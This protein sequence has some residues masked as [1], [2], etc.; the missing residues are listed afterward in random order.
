VE[1]RAFRVRLYPTGS[2]R[3]LLEK[4]FG[5]NRFTWNYF[6]Q[7]RTEYYAESKA[8]GKAQGMNYFKTTK[9]LTQLKGEKEWL[10]EISSQSLQQTLR[11]LDNAFTAFFRKNSSYPVFR[12]KK[13]KQ[14]FV[15][16]QGAKCGED[17][18]FIPK[19]MEGIRFRD[20]HQIPEEINQVIVT[21]EVDRYY[22]SIIYESDEHPAKGNEQIGIDM[23]LKTFAT[24]SNGIQIENP[25]SMNKFERG[26]KRQQ[27]KLSGK[28]KG[29]KNRA[30]QVIRIR[31]L[32]Q[33]LTDAR[34][35]FLHKASTAIAKQS[36][37]IVME[38]LN[39]QGMMRNHHL[40]KS[41]GDVS[42]YSFKRMLEYKAEWRGIEFIE[43]GMF[44]ASSRV[45]S[46]C[47]WYKRDL[48]LSD[49]VFH[50]NACGLVID[51]DLN[52]AIN[53]RNMGLIKVGRGTPE[54]TPVE[55][56]TSAELFNR[57][58]LRDAGQ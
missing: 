28:E 4:H 25:H 18:L 39:I 21:K 58:G 11:K 10:Y 47:G 16:P 37:T 26:I 7:K 27:K 51:R 34:E 23:G 54:F 49:R 15:T 24:L 36:D 35:D 42:W 9:L 17:R 33:H 12:S 43:I 45:C 8:K 44:E 31:K 22:A 48:K 32:Y 29:S 40:A 41:I 2:Q 5:A 57:G 19:F 38:D 55:I 20:K 46:R 1:T 3:E 30:K 6:L 56:A 53:I 14:Y 13:G 50:C 52:A